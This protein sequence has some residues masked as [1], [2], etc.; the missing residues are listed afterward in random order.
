MKYTGNDLAG[1]SDPFGKLLLGHR[2]DRIA[3]LVLI[4]GVKKLTDDTLTH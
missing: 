4:R 3:A 2:R 1:R